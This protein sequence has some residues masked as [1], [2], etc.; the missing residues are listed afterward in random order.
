MAG[1]AFGFVDPMLPPGVFLALRSADLMA[2]G[3]A[4]L[5]ARREIPSPEQ[6]DCV[7][8]AYARVQNAMRSRWLELAAYF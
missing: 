5:L 7:L 4:P 2:D 6:L 3:L 1:D 8:A